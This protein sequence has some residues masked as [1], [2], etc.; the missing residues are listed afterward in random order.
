MHILVLEIA[1]GS[2][3]SNGAIW[4]E[5]SKQKQHHLA[6]K[7]HH[8]QCQLYSSFSANIVQI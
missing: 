4:D 1:A 6:P 8:I 7:K 3:S 5:L 2:T